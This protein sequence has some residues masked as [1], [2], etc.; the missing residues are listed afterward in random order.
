MPDTDA[1]CLKYIKIVRVAQ[2][3]HHLSKNTCCNTLCFLVLTAHAKGCIAWTL[4]A[5]TQPRVSHPGLGTQE[6]FLVR[7]SA[8]ASQKIFTN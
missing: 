5:R 3:D 4:C 8:D 7:T 6:L 1:T 2:P